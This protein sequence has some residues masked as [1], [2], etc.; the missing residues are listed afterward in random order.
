MEKN[1]IEIENLPVCVNFSFFKGEKGVSEYHFSFTP[2]KI[3]NFK[4]QLSWIYEAYMKTLEILKIEENTSVFRRFFCSDLHNQIENLKENEFSNSENLINPTA[5]SYICQAPGPYAKVSLWAYHIVEPNKKLEKKIKKNNVSIVRNQLIHNWTTGIYTTESD[6]IYEQS[7][8]IIENYI[9]FL[10]ENNMKLSE[11]VIRTWFFL[12]NIDADYKDFVIARRE[13]YEKNGLTK[14]THYIA[15]TGVGG[16]YYDLRAKVV[17][18]AYSI[19]NIKEEQ[20]RFLSAPDFL[21]P[22]YIYGVT[23]ERGVSIT[24]SDRKHII[25]SGTA[26]INNKGEIMYERDINLQTDRTLLN[27]EAL[28]KNQDAGLDDMMIFIVYVRDPIDY[29]FVENKMRERFKDTPIIFATASVCRPK[30]LVEIEGIAVKP[31]FSD[32]PD[33]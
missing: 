26:S 20:I 28:L 3:E 1:R 23:F 29:F 13:I 22:T 10:N 18:D 31:F 32:F 11:N 8:S 15:S 4:T 14:D 16:S 2:T 17:L 19:S 9:K 12:Q 21:S 33:F 25:I 30:W 24:Y 5:I 7:K 6:S 27:I